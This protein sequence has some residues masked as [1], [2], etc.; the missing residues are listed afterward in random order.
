MPAATRKARSRNAAKNREHQ[1]AFKERR[2]HG[3]KVTP[4][5]IAYDGRVVSMLVS[6]GWLAPSEMHDPTAIWSAINRMVKDVDRNGW[7]LPR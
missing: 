3:L 4:R 6:D 2:K 1:R 5:G 7:R